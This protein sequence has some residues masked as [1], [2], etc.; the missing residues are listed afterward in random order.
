MLKTL[1]LC[2]DEETRAAFFVDIAE[3]GS[4]IRS[5]PRRELPKEEKEASASRRTMLADG[6][7]K[8]KQ[9]RPRPNRG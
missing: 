2:P 4:K 9:N 5:T 8:P 6:E 7:V 1:A 3:G